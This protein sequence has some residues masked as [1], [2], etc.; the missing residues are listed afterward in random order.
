MHQKES[1]MKSQF[2]HLAFVIAY[3]LAST[4]LAAAQGPSGGTGAIASIP[5]SVVR[6][7]EQR[8]PVTQPGIISIIAGSTPPS[9]NADSKQK[10]T[11][12]GE[13]PLPSK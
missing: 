6:A 11:R 9:S 3:S 7:G 10:T 13:N 2:V 12:R 8:Q 4:H 1:H 5:S